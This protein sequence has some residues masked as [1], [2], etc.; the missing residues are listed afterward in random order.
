ML[1]ITDIPLPVDGKADVIIYRDW[2]I[3]FSGPLI[4]ARVIF[5]TFLLAVADIPGRA[6]DKISN[7]GSYSKTPFE[8]GFL[9]MYPFSPFVWNFTI[10]AYGETIYLA[11][12]EQLHNYENI[13]SISPRIM[14]NHKF[15]FRLQQK[16][17][18]C[19]GFPCS[20]CGWHSSKY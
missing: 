6:A 3:C 13:Q 20:I 16:W 12:P 7:T 9:T 15:V 10:F 19:D 2:Q 5:P 11:C 4:D 14:P 1:V 18:T 8:P 17:T